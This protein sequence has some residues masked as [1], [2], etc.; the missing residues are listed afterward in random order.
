MPDLLFELGCEELPAS[1]VRGAAR[2]LA[3]KI[4]S[5]LKDAGID[6]GP[7]TVYSTPR[8]LIVGVDGLPARQPDQE[9]VSRGPAVKAAFDPEG[10]PT[11]ALEG[12]CR[13][14]G[15]DLSQ[16]TVE[17]EH[18]WLKFTVAGRPTH[19][20][21]PE[22]L[23]SAVRGVNFGKTMRWGHGTLRFSRPIRWI[24]AAFDA[25]RVP[26]QIE[27]VASGL[28]SRGHRHRSPEPFE[29]T[30]LEQ[31]VQGLRQRS[32]EPDPDVRERAIREGAR[33]CAQG[34]PDLSDSLVEENAFLG[35]WPE[36]LQG[37]FPEA[38]LE[39]PEPVLVTV[40]AKH[41]RFFPVRDSGGALTNRFVSVRHGGEEAVV[42][43]GNTWV[44]IARFNDARFFYD[45]DS[46]GSLEDFLEK[47]AGM[48]F[49]ERLGT[50]RSRAD[51]LADLAGFVAE[52]AGEDLAVQR[53][54][55][56][57]GRLAKADLTTGVVGELD[58]LQGVV[59]GI[60]ARREGLPEEVA[61]A[62]ES[63]YDLARLKSL[64]AKGI[65]PAFCLG[66]ADQIDKL[67]GY[68][69]VGFEP[70]GTSD[71]FGLRRAGTVL[72]ELAWAAPRA[73]PS[74]DPLFEK[75]LSGYLGQGVS[76]DSSA[77]MSALRRLLRGRYEALLDDF[78]YDVRDGAIAFEDR[79]TAPRQVLFQAKALACLADDADLVQTA[80]RP[81]N[82]VAAA[83][84]K[85]LAL[86]S[87]WPDLSDLESPEG[88]ALA[89]A[90][91]THG[92]L[93]LAAAAAEDVRAL[94]D[95]FRPLAAPI[96]AFFDSTMV[97]VDEARVRDAR[98]ALLGRTADVFSLAGDFTRLVAGA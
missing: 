35:E 59:G 9:K 98:L 5:G 79:L 90:V 12:F 65:G 96:N 3:A 8:R 56:Q 44:L 97:M 1:Q 47:T 23:E 95:S 49:Q 94:A 30:S 91:T 25:S 42:R 16:V 72:I 88:R 83:Q 53:E 62:I 58:E 34:T 22:I 66:L 11:K 4:A 27:G 46:K 74:L 21:L 13:G 78:R 60:Y 31:L 86:G 37:E 24:L 81:A 15:A 75:A 67:A 85:G 33:S 77:A 43:E 39:L 26:M 52:W 76:V 82:I 89:E 28:L 14:Q 38:F 87:A 29:A 18:V 93:A 70:S 32:V 51:R 19:E 41:E 57:A 55:S 10:K 84:K 68:L 36:P 6:P 71:P 92:A 61:V 17:G 54:A 20:L 2:Q 45:D 73:L 64:A 63:Q 80:T 40:M 50:V 48:T 7:P 69:G